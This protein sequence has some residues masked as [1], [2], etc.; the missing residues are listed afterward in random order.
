MPYARPCRYRTQDAGNRQFERAR[1]HNRTAQRHDQNGQGAAGR[2]RTPGE[3]SRGTD[4]G[5]QADYPVKVKYPYGPAVTFA[6]S[7][8][9]RTGR[10]TGPG[11]A[12]RWNGCRP[13]PWSACPPRPVSSRRAHTG[14]TCRA[15]GRRSACTPCGPG[16]A[17]WSWRTPDAGSCGS[18]GTAS[19][20]AWRPCGAVSGQSLRDHR[21]R[22]GQV[23]RAVTRDGLAEPDLVA[24]LGERAGLHARTGGGR[25]RPGPRSRD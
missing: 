12:R 7:P 22:A 6:V 16:T 1:N 18:S 4:A 14:S 17:T 23:E 10:R 9:C 5:R 25:W 2:H 13:A 20:R 15:R 19:S 11:S 3:R 8:T 24:G 21:L